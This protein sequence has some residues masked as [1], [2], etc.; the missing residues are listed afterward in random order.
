MSTPGAGGTGRV[1]VVGS[2]N[3]DLVMRLPALPGPGETVLGGVLARHHGGKGANQ[4]VAAARA[5]ADVV[6]VGAVGRE[7]GSASVAE[8]Q[9]EGIDVTHVLRA[10]AP[11][12]TAAILVDAQSGE[13][14]IAVASGANELV[15][16]DVVDAAL[17]A[18]ALQPAD[19]VVL[20]FELPGP[21]LERAAEIS[22][23]VGA[24]LVV[25]PAPAMP[26]YTAVLT[27][28]VATPNQHELAA[29]LR[30]DLTDRGRHVSCVPPASRPAGSPAEGALALSARTGGPVLVTLGA[31]G[32]LLAAA[33]KTE[34][35]AGHR[36]EPV[37][38]TGAG[39][40]LTGVLAASLAAG[41]PLRDAARRAVAAGALSVTKAGARA[42]MPS[43]AEIDAL[44]GP[45]S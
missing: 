20:N 42:G 40:T 3:I 1:V 37:D 30:A 34:H 8:L 16:A 44:A 28:A 22:R 13:N 5:G 15:T 6:I 12:G 23:G 31:D 27:G 7:D 26:G 41:Y 43:A 36:V 9:A 11:T 18:I 10:D 39:D 24:H 32:A 14:L 38:T 25:N 2:V 19:V 21:A 4:A 29:Y 35:F 45:V 17:T 33:G